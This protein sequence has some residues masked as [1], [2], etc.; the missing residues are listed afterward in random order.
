M[1]QRMITKRMPIDHAKTKCTASRARR[2]NLYYHTPMKFRACHKLIAGLVLAAALLFGGM[3]H[4][5]GEIANATPLQGQNPATPP[6]RSGED[7]LKQGL[8]IEATGKL[9]EAVSFYRLSCDDGD[10]AG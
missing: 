5:P 7:L 2:V 1:F 4:A 3:G 8:S 6:A 10:A 9:P